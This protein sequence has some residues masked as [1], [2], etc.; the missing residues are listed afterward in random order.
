MFKL[1]TF[2]LSSGLFFGGLALIIQYW[3]TSFLG[4]MI[5]RRQSVHQSRC[6]SIISI[7]RNAVLQNCMKIDQLW[8]WYWSNKLLKLKLH[9]HIFLLWSKCHLFTPF[10]MKNLKLNFIWRNNTVVE[11][12]AALLG[13]FHICC[14]H[15]WH[16]SY[17][18][19]CAAIETT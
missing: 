10:Y 18:Y 2:N 19:I 3:V 15:A 5:K 7:T 11:V 12:H 4:F 6:S 17:N 9:L 14:K 1:I 16:F 13:Q 8:K